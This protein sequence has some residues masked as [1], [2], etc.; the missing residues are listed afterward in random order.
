MKE[1]INQD[2]SFLK[3][4]IIIPSSGYEGQRQ[5]DSVYFETEEA[6]GKLVEVHGYQK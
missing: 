5:Q 3:P 6:E 4:F 2:G 1:K